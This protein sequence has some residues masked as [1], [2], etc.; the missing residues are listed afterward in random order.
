MRVQKARWKV[1]TVEQTGAIQKRFFLLCAGYGKNNQQKP[2]E[3][4][5]IIRPT[6]YAGSSSCSLKFNIAVVLNLSILIGREAIA[7]SDK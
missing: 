3:M 4:F 1:F 5:T 6:C 7:F 2:R